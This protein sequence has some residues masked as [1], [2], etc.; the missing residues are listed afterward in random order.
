MATNNKRISTGELDFDRIKSN[1]KEYLRGQSEFS[2]YDFEGSGMSVLLDVLAY[3]TH[4]NALYTNLAVNESFLDSASKRS[5]VVSLAKMLSYTPT[6]SLSARAIVD[7]TVTNVSGSPS[8]LT[9][10]A[11]SAFNTTIDGENYTFYNLAAVTAPREGTR[12]VMSGIELVEGTPLEYR[13]TVEDGTRFI[14]PNEKADL[15]TLTVR[16]IEGSLYTTFAKSTSIMRLESTSRVY[17]TQEIDNG[18]QEVY[19]GDGLISYRPDNGSTVVLNYFVS[20]EDAANGARVFT[21][22]GTSLGGGIVAVTTT[23][24]ATGGSPQESID[25]IKFN[26]PRMLTAYNRAVTADDYKALLPNLYPNVASI[27]V[28]GGEDNDPP[29]YGKVYIA[30]KPK[31]GEVLSADTKLIIKRD[32][33]KQK[34]VVSIIPEIVDPKYLYVDV[35]T[36]LYYNPNETTKD[37]DTLRSLVRQTI[38]NYNDTELSKFDGILR[39]SKLQAAIDNTDPS[40]LSNIT[41]I[42]LRK[43]QTPVFNTS[44]QY[45]VRVNNPIYTE[46]VPEDSVLSTGFT[47]YGSTRTYYLVDEGL[48]DEVTKLGNLRMFY[49]ETSSNQRTYLT[50]SFGT[51][52]YET[53]TLYIDALNITSA[54][55]N[56]IEFVIKPRSYDVASIRDNLV[57]IDTNKIKTTAIVDATTSGN[58]YGSSSYIFTPSR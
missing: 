50:D 18:L 13:Y 3:N 39:Y 2:D 56:E 26:A 53:G 14:I 33:L 23:T 57:T 55:N 51:V 30:V 43:K 31:T 36:T 6:S 27:S 52:D 8:Y 7:I 58:V 37:A 9:I 35:D 17:Y 38:V 28:W 49:F 10:P 47:I 1:L 5:N 48:R 15:T 25:S 29:N 44:A 20:S 45:I 16:A 21:Y 54:P 42:K 34:N 40:I 32:I 46:D 11:L 12:Y 22:S 4:Y 19:F 24:A 41:T